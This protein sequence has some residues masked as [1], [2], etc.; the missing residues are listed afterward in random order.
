MRKN[1]LLIALAILSVTVYGQKVWNVGNDPTN[2]PVS[3]G[4]GAGPDHSFFIDGLGIH[5]GSA[6]NVNM[7]QV[8]ASAKTFTSLT[9]STEYTFINRFKFNGGGYSGSAAGDETPSTMMPT[10]RYLTVNVS[11]NSTLYFIGT[12]GSSSSARKMFVTNGT[13]LIGTLD[14]PD[15]TLQEG[16][17]EYTGSATTL[18]I[19]CN[20][21]INLYYISATNAVASSV[22]TID[23]N[24]TIVSEKLY[25]ILGHEIPA[26]SKGLVLRKV[27]YSDGTESTVKNFIRWEN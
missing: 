9:T 6:T 11:G 16:S 12:S 25:N 15:G 17:V 26:T 7:G 18:Y 19:Y 10:Q 24:K 23:T 21:A 22:N 5:T 2:F 3:A 20:A 8:E 14:Y 13:N 1:L 4:I 27:S